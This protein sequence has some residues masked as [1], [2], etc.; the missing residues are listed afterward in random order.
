VSGRDLA[1]NPLLTGRGLKWIGAQAGLTTCSYRISCQ[2]SDAIY[3]HPDAPEGT[4]YRSRHDPAALCLA[5][6][7]RAQ[8]VVAAFPEGT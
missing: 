1:Q 6:Y 8:A 2:W 7:D 3:D 5:I 4:L